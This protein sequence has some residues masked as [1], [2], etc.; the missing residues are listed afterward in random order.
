MSRRPMTWMQLLVVG[1]LTAACGTTVPGAASGGRTA[2]TL[3]PG[4]V[5]QSG[6]A[7]GPATGQL[8]PASGGA[9][10]GAP[11]GPVGADSAG[12]VT[13]GVGSATAG[14]AG[15]GSSGATAVGPLP[16]GVTASTVT[17]AVMASKT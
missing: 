10:V 11:A 12:G 6:A 4:A 15:A 1:V 3:Q 9:A 2:T 7:L 17:I 14:Q 8:P 5:G 16:R 13:G